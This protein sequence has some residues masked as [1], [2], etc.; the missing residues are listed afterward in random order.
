MKKQKKIFELMN[1]LNTEKMRRFTLNA[2]TFLIV[3]V[4]D[5]FWLFVFFRAY[6]EGGEVSGIFFILMVTFWY[7]FNLFCMFLT[8]SVQ[9][10]NR[11]KVIVNEI[12]SDHSQIKRVLALV[13]SSIKYLTISSVNIMFVVF[14][15]DGY[16]SENNISK[17]FPLGILV[18][19]IIYNF[20]NFGL[21]S[22]TKTM[23]SK[24]FY[25][26]LIITA[27]VIIFFVWILIV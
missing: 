26:L 13:M 9:N 2:I 6:L 10:G 12:T 20:L 27:P 14:I 16:R 15:I 8:K 4:V 3:L 22:M 24:E 7:V 18:V 11:E 23:K 1:G 17:S 21:I 19:I 5:L 25:R